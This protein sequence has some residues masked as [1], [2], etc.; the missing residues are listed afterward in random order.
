MKPIIIGIV[1]EIN[2]PLDDCI[3]TFDSLVDNLKVIDDLKTMP[4]VYKTHHIIGMNSQ[5]T[6]K[7]YPYRFETTVLITSL[8]TQEDIDFVISTG[9]YV[10]SIQKRIQR[11]IND[12]KGIHHVVKYDKKNEMDYDL[13]EKI[14]EYFRQI[15]S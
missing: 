11:Q 12:F 6:L 13:T 4:E 7:F 15:K 2:A 1:N 14:I 3:D 5:N 10:I 8:K 9:G